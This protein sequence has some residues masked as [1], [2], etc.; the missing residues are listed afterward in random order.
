MPARQYRPRHHMLMCWRFS[1]PAMEDMSHV[2]RLGTPVPCTGSQAETVSPYAKDDTLRSS[3]SSSGRD[4]MARAESL[5]GSGIAPS[6]HN[7]ARDGAP[8]QRRSSAVDSRAEIDARAE[9]GFTSLQP[10][11]GTGSARCC[12]A[13]SHPR[14]WLDTACPAGPLTADGS[15]CPSTLWHRGESKRSVD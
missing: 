1:G 2:R 8:R 13:H 15:K 10:L 3:V 4:F 5:S 14:Q 12:A 7:E 6:Q 11:E 9:A